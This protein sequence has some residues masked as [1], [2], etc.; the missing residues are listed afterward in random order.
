MKQTG[1]EKHFFKVFSIVLLTLACLTMLA[2]GSGGSDGSGSGGT[3]VSSG[4]TIY[5]RVTAPP[6]L[7]LSFRLQGVTGNAVARALVWLENDPANTTL[8]DENGYFTLTN[9]FL[10]GEQRVISRYDVAATGQIFLHRSEPIVLSAAESFKQLQDLQL[11]KGLYSIYGILKNQLGQPVADARLQLWGIEFKSD[12]NGRF[13]SPPLPESAQTEKLKIRAP[14]YTDLV[15]D[16]PI[17]HSTDQ[18]VY[19]D[20][21]LSGTNQPNVSPVP[22]F[23]KI[24]AQTTPGQRLELSL[25]VIDPDELLADQFKPKWS[26]SAGTI[27]ATADPLRVFWTAPQTSGLATISAKVTDS[28]GAEGKVD[29]GIA[30]GG[31]KTAVL[32][33]DRLEPAA[34]GIGATV[35]IHGSGFGTDLKKIRVSFNGAIAS[36]SECIDTRITTT[37][38]AEATTGILLLVKEDFEKSAGVFTIL[39]SSLSMNPVYGPP[40]TV[41]TI[42]GRDFGTSAEGSAVKVNG[43][44]A[45]TNSWSDQLISATVP[46]GATGGVVSLEI[47]GKTRF[48]GSFKV[49]RVFEIS[50]TKTRAGATIS[51]SGEGWG[52][53]IGNSFIEFFGGV[54]AT[55]SSWSDSKVVIGVPSAAASG[56]LSA[57]LQNIKFK[58]ADVEVNSIFAI[59]PELVIPGDEVE[60]TGTGFG[61]S[62]LNSLVTIG[63]T[64]AEIVSWSDTQ[65]RFRVPGSTLPGAV[66]VNNNGHLSNQRQ[67]KILA[68]TSLSHSRRPAGADLTITGHGFGSETGFVIFGDEVISS[69]S[70]WNENEIKLKIPETAAG[71]VSIR[72][73]KLGVRSAEASFTAAVIGNI[74]QSDGWV[75]REILITGQYLGNGSNGDLVSFAGLTAPVISWQEEQIRVRVP[76]NAETGPVKLTLS[77]WPVTLADEFE[78]Y[79]QY[80]YEQL[81]PNWSGPRANS[82]PLLPGIAQDGDGNTYISDF[83]NGWVW[84]ITSA[85]KQSKFGNFSNP[86]G[87]AYSTQK[88]ELFIADSGN[89]SI[90]VFDTNG[91]FIRS[92]GSFGT[93]DGQFKSPRGLAI[94]AS[95]L[96]FVADSG[97]SRIQVFAADE[98]Y[99]TQF[100]TYGGN[101]GQFISPSGIAVA[102][103]LVAY[104]ADAGNHR[105]QRFSVNDNLSPTIWSFS[106]WLGSKDPN[107]AT[108][109]WLTSGSGLASDR[110]SGFNQ[111]YGCGISGNG[112]LL[113]ADT[114]NNRVQV[115]DAA[116]G[117]FENLIGSAG[118]TSGQYNQPITIL[119]LAEENVAL[120]A[121][122]S[123]AR[124]QKSTFSGAYIEQLIPDTSRLNTNPSRI[125]VDSQR[126]RVYVL[127]RADGSITVYNVAGEVIQI[128]GS[129]GSGREQF[130]Q[131]EGICV[132]LHGNVYVADTGN[133]R[134]QKISAEGA[135][136]QNWGVYGN[137]S[138]QFHKPNAIAVSADGSFLFISDLELH[139]IQ[140]FSNNG[141]FIGG[142]GSFGNDDACFNQPSGI[143]VASSDYLYIADKNNHRIKKYDLNGSLIGWWG[144]YDAGAQAFWLDPG[145]NRTGAISDADGGFDTPTD[146]AVDAEGNVFV[147][148]SNNF[149]IQRF[150]PE[151]NTTANAGFQTDIYI[152]DNL[153]ALTTDAWARI[154]CVNSGQLLLRFAPAP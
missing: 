27:E 121:D 13:A 109:G 93:G 84:K 104:V 22:Y 147:T 75:G 40:G 62:A 19:F 24:P 58:I 116:S 142:W 1:T 138:G 99:L 144:S 102:T 17:L 56:E 105:I 66:T 42:T 41:L 55:I 136:M 5:G 67:L 52:E 30:V 87:L 150:S 15:L 32:R 73:S 23:E 117:Q 51:I 28:R 4:G 139:R 12:L 85:G 90:K 36:V 46:S 88:Q 35:N 98:S 65:I 149:R 80:D 137:G 25:K 152:G 120:I 33:V 18:Q 123:N 125:A 92:L 83:D 31:V 96:L 77:A 20:I 122:S 47:R 39:D 135:F 2:C 114:Y 72:V 91:N 59:S 101:N 100:G 145:S 146:V 132:D 63:N 68:I 54:K 89:N 97:N 79:K 38:P 71:P 140:K 151:Q 3:A 6:E 21:T 134:I 61:D 14:G 64:S 10:N 26:S 34:A 127:D 45:Q 44:L 48:A 110:T 103:D 154:Y 49:T 130:F 95:G 16:L 141:E 111:P 94:S 8:T 118:I 128:I 7:S 106:G 43:V 53:N 74:D 148:D 119:P 78:I 82:R 115:F 69:F 50:A 81:S 107:A 133:A 76:L 153:L 57:T 126:E 11:S 124:L 129:S 37:V 113:V 70:S 60:I 131:P 9:V 29:L 143:A 86:W 112:K 108:P